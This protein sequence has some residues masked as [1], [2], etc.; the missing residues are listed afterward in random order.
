MKQVIAIDLAKRVFQIHIPTSDNRPALNKVLTRNKLLAF[1]ANQPE[2]IIVMEACGTA[3]YWCNQFAQFGHEVRQ[4]SPQYVA[5]FR[6]GN[7]NDRNDAIAISEAF[8]RP[9]MRFVPIKK[10]EQQ[11]RQCL[12]RVRQRLVKNRTAIINQ[13]HGLAAEYGMALSEGKHKMLSEILDELEDGSNGLSPIFRELLQELYLE[14]KDIDL[15]VKKLSS[16]ITQLNSISETAQ[17]L[18][19]IPGVGPLSAS[20]L[21]IE[22]GDGAC[23][24]NGRHFSS[25]LGL[26]PNER[27]SG[28]KV[29]LLG[30]TKRGDSY[31]RGLLIH[32]ARAVVYRVSKLPLEQ[33]DRLQSWLKKLITQN[34]VNKAIVALA[35]KNARMAWAIVKTGEAYKAV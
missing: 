30:I 27:S 32:G 19:T 23:F 18:L 13:I 20:V 9:D 25:Y 10:I 12:H 2:S 1:I 31:L 11:D 29:R 3:N 35:N 28:G 21:G 26:V 16:Q 17:K 15:K 7:K 33:C 4:I 34:G 14:F 24:K 5:R 8:S 22:L 6:I